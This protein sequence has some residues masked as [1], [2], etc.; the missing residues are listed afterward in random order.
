LFFDDFNFND[1]F[2][3]DWDFN[4]SV[5]VV[6]V[7]NDVFSGNFYDNIIR[8]FFGDFNV[9]RNFLND[10]ELSSLFVHLGS[11]EVS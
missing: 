10:L 8:N 2:L 3:M 4:F 11:R 1:N 5:Y 6:S 9:F 7:L